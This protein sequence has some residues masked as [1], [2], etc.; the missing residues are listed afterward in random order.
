MAVMRSG[1]R[2]TAVV[3]VALGIPVAALGGVTSFAMTRPDDRTAALAAACAGWA[4]RYRDARADLATVDRMWR[5]AGPGGRRPV[6]RAEFRE[7]VSALA[8][9]R[10]ERCNP[11]GRLT[12]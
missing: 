10:P 5:E 8:A 11:T 2:G 6:E 7:R 12:P 9:I 1:W 4:D 3:I